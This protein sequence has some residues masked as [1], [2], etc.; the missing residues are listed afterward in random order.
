M[1]SRAFLVLLAPIVVLPFLRV[2]AQ[3]TPAPAQPHDRLSVKSKAR[4]VALADVLELDFVVQGTAEE[5]KEAEK[6]HRD[7]LKHLVAALT[8]ADAGK[9]DEEPAEDE[10]DKPR[11]KT[12]K[13]KAAE[14][15]EGPLPKPGV[16]DEDG[17]V[18]E[19]REGRY[20]LGIKGDPNQLVDDMGDENLPKKEVELACGSCVH[21]TLKHLKKSSP[22]KVRRLLARILDRAAEAGADLGPPKTRLKPA[23]R[24]RS[25]ELDALKKQ[26]YADAIT[27]GRARATELAV[28]AGRTLGKVSVVNDLADGGVVQSTLDDARSSDYEVYLALLQAVDP[29]GSDAWSGSSEI[30]VEASLELEFELR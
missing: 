15:A 28:L 20:T 26:A 27:R 16:P 29:S 11:K 2:G 5:A 17:L 9:D 19:V 8:G 6:K 13:K 7:R 25:S 3:D 21:V 1:R 18:L 30:A 14:D 22:K 24:F 4:V 10:D 23:L 12:K